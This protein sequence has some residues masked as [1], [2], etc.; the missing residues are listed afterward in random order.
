MHCI[1]WGLPSREK[2]YEVGLIEYCSLISNVKSSPASA[3]HIL[4]SNAF[5]QWFKGGLVQ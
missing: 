2:A 4:F 5:K 1:D 3:C